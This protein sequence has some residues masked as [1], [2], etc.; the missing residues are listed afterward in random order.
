[1]CVSTSRCVFDLLAPGVCHFL[2]HV[3][4]PF[5]LILVCVVI[6]SSF[7]HLILSSY[8]LPFLYFTSVVSLHFSCLASRHSLLQCLSSTFFLFLIS[9]HQ[10]NFS[11]HAL[12]H[13][14]F[15]PVTSS[16]S[17]G[18]I[19][20]PDCQLFSCHKLPSTIACSRPYCGALKPGSVCGASSRAV[21]RT[22]GHSKRVQ[23]EWR[24]QREEVNPRTI[25]PDHWAA[26]NQ[27]C[28]EPATSTK[29][30]LSR[31][32]LFLPLLQSSNSSV[33]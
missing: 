17:P 27:V 22:M 14:H 3:C 12:M 19:A 25:K 8:F 20:S 32:Y 33:V 18:H 30:L 23:V 29:L 10:H 16:R 7:W 4:G 9:E 28:W 11:P 24:R 31:L 26:A 5:I 13:L 21:T 1:M 6:S 15:N 2:S